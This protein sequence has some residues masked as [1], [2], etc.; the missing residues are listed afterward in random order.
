MTVQCERE[1]ERGQSGRFGATERFNRT[2]GAPICKKARRHFI[3]IRIYRQA[4]RKGF[5]RADEPAATKIR[6]FSFNT[7]PRSSDST[8]SRITH[9]RGPRSQPFGHS[10]IKSH[11]AKQAF[12]V[13]TVRYKIA[14]DSFF[15][16]SLSRALFMLYLASASHFLRTYVLRNFGDK[17][18]SLTFRGRSRT[19][20]G[21]RFSKLV[22][23]KLLLA[24]CCNF[25]VMKNIKLYGMLVNSF[26]INSLDYRLIV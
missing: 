2:K 23:V 11:R 12:G 3:K 19:D 5:R 8:V 24:R 26:V 18:Y 15:T 20:K 1:R 9:T 17:W 25:E 16:A 6:A 4:G 7:L 13:D 10:K 22:H 21:Y 14:P